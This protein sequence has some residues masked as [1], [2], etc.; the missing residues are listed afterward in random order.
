LDAHYGTYTK[1]PFQEAH[2]KTLSKQLWSAL[3]FLHER[4]ILHRDI[5]PSN[6]LYHNGTL[7]L[8]DFGLARQFENGCS[9]LTPNVVSMWYRAPELLWKT[10]ATTYTTAIDMWASGC[11]VAE[12][13]LGVPLL[14]GKSEV[15]QMEKIVKCI[16]QP[17]LSYG[18]RICARTPLGKTRSGLELTDLLMN[19]IS[20]KGLRLL[21]SLLDYQPHRRWTAQKALESEFLTVKPLPATDMPTNFVKE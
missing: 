7:K 4:A 19:H 16:G 10:E 12:L 9:R 11:V 6:L 1:S 18:T 14:D 20:D 17:P 3:H 13:I 2:V 21:V 8:A 15:E 5:K